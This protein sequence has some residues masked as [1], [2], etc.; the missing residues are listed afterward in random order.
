VGELWLMERR[1]RRNGALFGST[2]IADRSKPNFRRPYRNSFNPLAP[3][4]NPK[5][6][7]LLPRFFYWDFNS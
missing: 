1:L 3:E 2:L 5:A 6:Q 4:L 7:R